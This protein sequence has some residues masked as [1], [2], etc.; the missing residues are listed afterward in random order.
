MTRTTSP[1]TAISDQEEQ[2]VAESFRRVR[3]FSEVIAAPLSPEDCVIQ[4]MPDVS[5]T[6]WHLAQTTWFFETFVL[7]PRGDYQVFSADYEYL[8][9]SYYNS[10][11]KQF[12]RHQRGLL[13]RPT[14]SEVL[15]YRSYVDAHVGDLVASG[16]LTD[17]QCGVI[18]LGLNHE[19]QHQEL[20]LTDI[21]HVLACNPLFPVYRPTEMGVS[22]PQESS[23]RDFAGGIHQLGH[24]GQGFAFDNESPRHRVLL[25]DYQLAERLVTTG[26][27]LAF[28]EDGGYQ[29]PSYWLSLGWHTVREQSWQAPLYWHQQDG[30]WFEFT[31]AGLQPID[32]ARPRLSCQLLRG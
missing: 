13:S 23:F 22:E 11:G 18:E 20:M 14:V 24:E 5:P 10:V 16:E 25:D 6:R 15:E 17:Q 19:Q 3:A 12:P 2:S 4:T 31:L 29:D 21:K 30:E 1:S 8:F 7:K 32:L 28:M 27:Y 9:N 26:E